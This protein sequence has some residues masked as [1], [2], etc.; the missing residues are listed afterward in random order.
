MKWSTVVNYLIIINALILNVCCIIILMDQ[1]C[2][3]LNFSS[4]FLGIDCIKTS[5]QLF[6]ELFTS[7]K[8]CEHLY[9]DLHWFICRGRFASVDN[10]LQ[11]SCE[12]TIGKGNGLCCR[13]HVCCG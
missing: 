5:W 4:F 7:L 8:A 3:G 1:Y 6:G 2:I 9:F 11:F 10:D 12:C 13:V